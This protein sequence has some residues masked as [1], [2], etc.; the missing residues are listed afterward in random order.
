M[1]ELRISSDFNRFIHGV[2]LKEVQK[3][4]FLKVGAL[5]IAIKPRYLSRNALKKILKI[6]DDEYPK[7]KNQ[8]PFSYKKLNELDFLKHI[9]FIE[10]LCAENGYTLNLDKDLNNELS[11]PKTA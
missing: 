9:A 6:I 10:C 11:K 2:V 8:E 5:K 4:P 1:L 7:D 3:I